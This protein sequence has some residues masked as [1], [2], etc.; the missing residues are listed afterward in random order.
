MKEY[1]SEGIGPNNKVARSRL[2]ILSVTKVGKVGEREPDEV[3]RVDGPEPDA[4]G[5]F[6]R[7]ES[8]KVEVVVT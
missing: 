2:F 8:A 4:A 3:S 7:T 5:K 6:S 1:A